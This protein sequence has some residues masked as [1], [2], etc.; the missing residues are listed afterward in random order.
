MSRFDLS[1]TNHQKHHL[2]LSDRLLMLKKIVHID[3]F[4]KMV[5]NVIT[6][7]IGGCLICRE[8]GFISWEKNLL[9]RQS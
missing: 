2:D 4:V 5:Y 8:H 1:P 7:H 6:E 3:K 9:S